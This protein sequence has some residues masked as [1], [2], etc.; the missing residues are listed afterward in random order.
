MKQ[1]FTHYFQKAPLLF[2]FSRAK[3]F[4]VL[5]IC[6]FI[7]AGSIFGQEQKEPLEAFCGTVSEPDDYK[8][9]VFFGNNQLLVDNLIK[10]GF[11]IDENYLNRLGD[12]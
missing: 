8:K 11:N 12:N 3:V 2:P 1:S 9:A 10:E 6:T 5:L 4:F 7:G